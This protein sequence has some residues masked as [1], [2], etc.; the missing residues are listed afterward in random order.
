[1][2]TLLKALESKKTTPYDLKEIRINPPQNN[3][4]Q[5]EGIYWDFGQ[6]SDFS[7]FSKYKEKS[8]ATQIAEEPVL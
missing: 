1:M 7:F 5:Q 6:I 2:Q 4:A 8:I 3:K